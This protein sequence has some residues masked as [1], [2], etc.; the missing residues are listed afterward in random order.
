MR[1]MEVEMRTSTIVLVVI[2]FLFATQASGQSPDLVA[3]AKKEGGKV[4]IY[5]SLETSVVE[6]VIQAFR[7]K[8]GLDAQYWRASAM[9]VM[10][11]SMSEYRAG[12]PIYD[13]VLNNSDPL[14]IMHQEGMIGK[15][16]STVT[17]K[18]PK[19]QIDPRLGPIVVT[20][21]SACSTT[22]AW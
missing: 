7:K 11:R 16:D 6:A 18:Y 1:N 20:A 14:L 3:A 9:S 17:Q 21:L 4:V 8:T 10:N 5:G 22:R 13:V 19:D 2:W 12:N 15:Y